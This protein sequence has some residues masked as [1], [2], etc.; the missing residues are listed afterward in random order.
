MQRGLKKCIGS[1][2]SVVSFYSFIFHFSFFML[3]NG[4]MPGR[5]Q[6][7]RICINNGKK[8]GE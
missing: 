2:D 4:H 3:R 6:G 5:Q 8:T 7:W 1:K